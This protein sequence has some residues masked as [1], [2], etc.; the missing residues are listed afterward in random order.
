MA[1][2]AM[3]LVSSI[4]MVSS[5]YAWFTLSTA[6]EV[7]GITT[8]VGANGNLEMAL[9]PK[10]GQLTSITSAAGDST[11]DIEEKNVT[12][13][14]LVD[15]S[16]TNVYGL[17]KIT[18]FPAALNLTEAGKIDDGANIL[19]TPSYGADGRV[20]DLLANASSGNFDIAE[21][22]F[23]PGDEH[24]V[25]AV[26]VASG[27][28][29]RQLDYRNARSAGNTA[30]ALAANLA[31]QSLNNRGS[32]LANIAIEY[33]MGADT[34]RFDETDVASLRAIINDLQADGGI[35]Y[36]IETSYLK[37]ILAA[38]ASTLSGAED[39][40]WQAV[41]GAISAPDATLNSVVAAFGGNLPTQITDGIAKFDATKAAVA[42]ADTKLKVLEAKLATDKDATF[43]WAE[44][45]TAMEPLA[46]PASMKINGFEADNVKNNL[47]E[48][49]SSVT[50]QGGLV[51][52]MATGG[53]V[54]ADIADQAGDYTASIS[55]EK[56]E[57][58]GI[59]LNNMKARMITATSVKPTYLER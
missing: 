10:D 49:V 7:T 23:Y 8:A 11:K 16:D 30:R 38:A 18:L 32:S 21:Q 51:V 2:I 53:G 43:S 58:Q 17:N 5:T 6:P 35:L 42:D 56:V 28:T 52:T 44:I 31:S 14:N 24:G 48:L 45:K 47:G 54:Y 20:S 26:G 37:Y 41:S 34:A 1:A 57:Y 15:L 4:M 29:P 40:V 13:G 55:I 33:G 25:R 19:K 46:N 39:T 9:L 50:A 59:V 36:Q 3:L 12:W 27:L 22:S